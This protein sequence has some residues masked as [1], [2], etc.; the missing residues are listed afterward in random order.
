MYVTGKECVPSGP[1]AGP[2]VVSMRS[3]GPEELPLVVSVSEI[4][5]LW[6]YGTWPPQ[7][8]ASPSRSRGGSSP[9]SRP[10]G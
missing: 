7:S 6:E 10:A 4:R 1:F 5:R 9:Y 3:Y 8:S 2:M